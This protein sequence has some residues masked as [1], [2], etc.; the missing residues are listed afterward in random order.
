[1]VVVQQPAGP[2][3]AFDLAGRLADFGAG[4]DQLVFQPLMVSLGGHDRRPGGLRTR[5]YTTDPANSSNVVND[6]RF[7]YDL[8]GRPKTVEAFEQNDAAVSPAQTTSS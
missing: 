8:L 3:A 7:T 2:F 6:T 5:T 1:M 4:L